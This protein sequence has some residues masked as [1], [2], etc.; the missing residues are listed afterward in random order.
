MRPV[1]LLDT[2]A[3]IVG[4]EAADVDTEYFSVQAVRE[5]LRDGELPRLRFDSAV[6]SGHLKVMKP[7]SRYIE[8]VRDVATEMGEEGI[9]SDADVH[10]LALGLHLKAIGLR[11]VLVSDDYSVQNMV[12]RLDMEFRSLV[13]QGIKRR[14]EWIIYCPGCRR[15]FSVPQ[16]GDL[17]PICGTGLRRK[18]GRKTSI[19]KSEGSSLLPG[20]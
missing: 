11:P 15:T 18:P 1:L 13:T 14:F 20:Y 12:D 2:S 5:E 7:D 9:L 3:F 6:R 8:E 17:C 4:Y 16:P 10:L 19:D